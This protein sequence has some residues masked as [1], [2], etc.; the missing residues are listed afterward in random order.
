MFSGRW[1]V[2]QTPNFRLV[3]CSDLHGAKPVNNF[4]YAVSGFGVGIAN[5]KMDDSHGQTP[6]KRICSSVPSIKLEWTSHPA[7]ELTL[8][9]P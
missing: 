3:S 5:Q 1:V 8:G 6:M 7:G 9:P 4:V 2:A